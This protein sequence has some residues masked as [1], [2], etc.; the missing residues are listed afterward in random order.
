M[1]KRI[2]QIPSPEA[3]TCLA[4]MSTCASQNVICLLL[5]VANILLIIGEP[6]VFKFDRLL[7]SSPNV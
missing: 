1:I 7:T 2:Q 3:E 6:K 5:F 4:I